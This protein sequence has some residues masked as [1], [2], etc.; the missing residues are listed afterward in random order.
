MAGLLLCMQAGVDPAYTT[1][2]TALLGT[3]GLNALGVGEAAVRS[4][5]EVR[6]LMP[7]A[8]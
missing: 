5:F 7:P 3:G 4:R 1:F 6:P 2:E 8:P